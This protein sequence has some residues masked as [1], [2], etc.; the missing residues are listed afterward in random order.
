MARTKSA[1]TLVELLVVISVIAL[2]IGILMPAIGS[3]RGTARQI[4]GA[5]MHKQL[6]LGQATYAYDNKGEYA[7]VN[8]SN[9]FYQ[10]LVVRPGVGTSLNWNKM[11]GNTSPTTPTSWFDWISPIMG[12]EMGF[13]EN[14]ARRTAQIFRDL[15]CPTASLLSVPYTG[16][17]TPPDFDDFEQIN[18]EE[19]FN[20]MSFLSPS[21]FHLWPTSGGPVPVIPIPGNRRPFM[22][23]Y[24]TPVDVAASFRPNM[25][26]IARPSSK[27][28]ITDGTRYLPD[29]N[30]LDFDPNHAPG[31]FGSFL[32]SSPIFNDSTAFHRPESPNASI[33]GESFKLSIRHGG[34][35][36]MNISR[37][38][39]SVASMDIEEAYLDPTP[40][41]PT[42]SIFNGDSATPESIDFMSGISAETGE[43]NPRL[44]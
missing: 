1:F 19:G 39:G 37:F 36:S 33:S 38:D 14:R 4:V 31:D 23:G 21:S 16:G 9:K 11:L 13:S 42:D 41:Y 35:R 3:A 22:T 6:A 20:Q 44:N 34:N 27:I 12:D 43:A 8:G 18:D 29:N 25:D 2:L 30:V 15:A 26:Q 17:S 24:S 28:L 10:S 5:S 40:W 7:G 32:T